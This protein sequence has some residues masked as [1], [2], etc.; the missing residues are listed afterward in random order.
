KSAY[1][2]QK[3][4]EHPE[5]LDRDNEEMLALW[6]KDSPGEEVTQ[7]VRNSL[8]N[9]KSQMRKKAGMPRRRKRRRKGAAAAG[10]P[11]AAPADPRATRPRASLNALEELEGH[12][13]ECLML[14]H[15]QN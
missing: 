4:A 5:L 14:A 3:Y 6:Q 1:F 13:D 8:A 7:Q 15:K 11:A 2:R 9:V 12:I 10:A